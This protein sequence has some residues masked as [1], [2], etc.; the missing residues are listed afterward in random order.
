[1]FAD[2]NASTRIDRVGAGSAG[3]ASSVARG[4]QRS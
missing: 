1:M 4:H 3:F 2:A